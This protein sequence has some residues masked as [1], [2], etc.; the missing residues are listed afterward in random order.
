MNNDLVEVVFQGRS[1]EVDVKESYRRLSYLS[2]ASSP[3]SNREI[4]ALL[5]GARARNMN[6]LISGI[7]IYMNGCFFQYIEGPDRHIENLYKNI[8]SDNRHKNIRLILNNVVSG[9]GDYESQR[10]FPEWTMAY[11]TVTELDSNLRSS[12]DDFVAWRTYGE[13]FSDVN[14]LDSFISDVRTYLD[15]D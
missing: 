14:K 2:D 10:M 13:E 12:L 8:A 4:E 3:F 7:L 15:A 5:K 11:K 9:I 6:H 1:F